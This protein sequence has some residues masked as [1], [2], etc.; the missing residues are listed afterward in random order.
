M[1]PIAY[2]TKHSYLNHKSTYPAWSAFTVCLLASGCITITRLCNILQYT[3]NVNG[4]KND[5]V[6]LKY[7]VEFWGCFCSKQSTF[8]L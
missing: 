2:V 8:N 6:Q 4:C 3:E 1:P 5:N 7:S